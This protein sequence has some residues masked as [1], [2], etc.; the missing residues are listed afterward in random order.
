MSSK[1]T[2]AFQIQQAQQLPSNLPATLTFQTTVT[3]GNHLLD[4]YI[5]PVVDDV[6]KVSPSNA[7][8]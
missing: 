4:D 7:P 2:S 8:Q 6:P 1:S 5:G 3:S